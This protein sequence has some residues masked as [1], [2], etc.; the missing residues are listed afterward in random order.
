MAQ[1]KETTLQI[2]QFDGIDQFNDGTF[3][4]PKK[5]FNIQNMLVV[6]DGELK[7]LNGVTNLTGA[8]LAGVRN[9]KLAKFLDFNQSAV[10]FYEPSYSTI[11]VPSGHVYSTSGGSAANYQVAIYYVGGGNSYSR[12]S[13][14]T[15]SIQLN[16]LT[17]SLPTNVPDYV[18]CIHVFIESPAGGY[19]DVSLWA[20]SFTRRN[21]VFPASITCPR[22]AV[23]VATASPITI[24]GRAAKFSATYGTDGT[25]EAGK[26]YYFGVAPWLAGKRQTVAFF[27]NGSKGYA[28]YVPEGKNAITM[29]MDFLP[30]GAPQVDTSPVASDLAYS[31]LFV[32]CGPTIEDGLPIGHNSSTG[33][34]GPVA[35]TS[36]SVSFDQ[37][38][39]S[40]VIVGTDRIVVTGTIPDLAYLKY[41]TAGTPPTNLTTNTYYWV[42][43]PVYS[44]GTTSFQL[45]ATIDGAIIDIAGVGVGTGVWNWKKAV[46]TVKE[47][48]ESSDLWPMADS[49]NAD[50]SR[51]GKAT[52]PRLTGLIDLN[53]T[54][55]TAPTTQVPKGLGAFVLTSLP[56]TP[57]VRREVL[58]SKF[59]YA[60]TTADHS[61]DASSVSEFYVNS[62]KKIQARIYIGR[63]WCVNGLNSPFYTNG[64]VLKPATVDADSVY[65][66]ITKFIEFFQNRLIL[67]GGT[68]D[69][70]TYSEGNF[71]YSEAGNPNLMGTSVLNAK[72]VRFGD[73]SEIRGLAI[74]SQDLSTVGA[75]TFLV[76]GKK[77]SI[78]TWNGEVDQATQ[79]IDRKTGFAGPDCFARTRFGPVFVGSDNV[80]FLQNSQ[81]LVP[82]GDDIRNIIQ[83][84]SDEQRYSIQAVDHQEQVKIAYPTNT[85]LDREIWL[86]MVYNNGGL[87]KK[88]SGPHIMKPFQ[89]EATISEFGGESEYR[90][91][92]L[93]S[94][95]YRRDDPGSFLNDGAKIQHSIRISRLGLQATH[96]LKVLNRVFLDLRIV[97]DEEFDI[98]LES[99]DGSQSQVYTETARLEDGAR[100]FKQ[101]WLTE[102][103]LARV[104][105][106]SI[107]NASDGDLSIYDV[108]LLF[109]MMRR[110]MLP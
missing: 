33:I 35:V 80:Y 23:T 76:V 3:L 22:P 17:V 91:S 52:D 8:A 81:L 85:D 70:V 107:E 59:Q 12:T 72:P 68:G 83:A 106:V 88:W 90:I 55:S 1:Q 40:V 77:D 31:H 2:N 10:A 94:N 64:Y 104:L 65:F 9:I 108:S 25:L 24:A 87:S 50:G 43:N 86:K 13:F 5:F 96:F 32:V 66:P 62:S 74:Y 34:Q 29:T 48:P 21:G 89:G 78:Y 54:I 103:F 93:D 98:V 105:S 44:G 71:G 37:S 67:A 51:V 39:A 82:F 102:R 109:S 30:F 42:R 92:F 56:H 101:C 41:T 46:F 60:F 45:S 7:S 36:E 14:T 84:L 100:Q 20:G 53:Q 69:A 99:Q 79:Q 27:T 57:S 19:A 26:I 95:L 28:V 15:E 63:L 11:P 18:H 97:Q 110:R 38:S 6:S 73:E 47:L 58:S 61:P 49:V 75:Q 16:G 4:D